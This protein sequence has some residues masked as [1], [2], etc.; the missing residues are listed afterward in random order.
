MQEDPGTID[1]APDAQQAAEGGPNP[2]AAVASEP[3]PSV[4]PES[5]PAE[6]D[7]LVEEQMLA[8]LAEGEAADRRP[9]AGSDGIR[10]P[11]LDFPQPPLGAPTAQPVEFPQLKESHSTSE[12]RN[13]ELLMDVRL[14]VSIEL[15]RTTMA[16]ADILSLGNG[17]VVELDKLAGEPVELLV[18]DRVIA[19]GEVVVVDENFGIR[20]TGLVSPQERIKS[21]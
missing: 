8:Q 10:E 16:I 1:Q 6:V 5:S 4:A 20:I 9:T 2:S 21:L 14:P 3:A 17:S 12:P 13:L 19:Q 7:R 15:G 18:N 11:E